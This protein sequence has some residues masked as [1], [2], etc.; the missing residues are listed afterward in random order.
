M[1][2]TLETILG[3]KP[4]IDKNAI[5]LIL[6]TIPGN[7]TFENFKSTGNED[8]YINFSHNY[9]WKILT[10]IL[11]LNPCLVFEKSDMG[12]KYRMQALLDNNIALWDIYSSCK[13]TTGRSSDSKIKNPT[14]NDVKGLLSNYPNIK[15]VYT[16]GIGT[17]KKFIKAN[18]Y[19]QSDF[20]NIVFKGLTS[21]SSAN[22]RYFDFQEWQNALKIHTM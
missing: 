4:I 21:T 6:G 1:T 8:Y 20:P 17:Y 11:G 5:T 9:F 3:F 14:L 10:K 15:Y 2:D 22:N 13:R 12:Y 18:K 19:I 16:N 7:K